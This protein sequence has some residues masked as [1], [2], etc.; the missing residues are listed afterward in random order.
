MRIVWSK[1][2]ANTELVIC[3]S[4]SFSPYKGNLAISMYQSHR[5]S[6]M[7][8]YK[9]L[10]ASPN[11]Y[12]SVFFVTFSMVSFNRVNIYRSAKDFSP[13]KSISRYVNPSIFI[14]AKRA[15]FHILLDKFNFDSTLSQCNSHI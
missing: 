13:D 12:L 8:L 2:F 11:S 6:Q 15:A 10:P 9:Y 14:N 5:S 1:T 3:F 7:K 4:V